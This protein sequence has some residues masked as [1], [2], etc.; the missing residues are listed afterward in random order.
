MKFI[1]MLTAISKFSLGA[2]CGS[3]ASKTPYEASMKKIVY[4]LPKRSKAY[5]P[6][7]LEIIEGIVLKLPILLDS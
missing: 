1:T 6:T 4:F 3:K 7:R 2:V 5:P